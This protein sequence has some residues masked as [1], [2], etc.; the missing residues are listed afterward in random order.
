MDSIGKLREVLRAEIAKAAPP[1]VLWATCKSANKE[2]GTMTAERDG[3]E[4]TDVLI[5]LGGNRSVPKAN[6]KVLLGIIEGKKAVTMLLY[7]DTEETHINGDGHG[8]LVKA[9][10]VKDRLNALEQ[11]INTL[12]QVFAAWTPVTQDGGAALKGAAATWYAQQLTTTTSS[13]LQNP[14]VKHG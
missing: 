11:D 6:S 3:V 14:K 7:C 4:Y 9:D 5:G 13:Q 2:E 8:G 1:T 10:A 12:K